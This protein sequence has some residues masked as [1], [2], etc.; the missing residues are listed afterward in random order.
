MSFQEIKHK[1]KLSH[2]DLLRYLQI[3]EIRDFS[4][5]E[6][7][8]NVNLDK[9]GIIRSIIGIYKSKKYRVI[10]TVSGHLI[11]RGWNTTSIMCKTEMGEGT[12]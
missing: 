8:H 1:Y 7:K 2:Q 12:V 10:S 4:D 9:N 11:E 3:R 6:M 5:K